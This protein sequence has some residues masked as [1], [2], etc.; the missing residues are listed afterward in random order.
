MSI[1]E[2]G[3]S[4]TIRQ[5]FRGK[6]VSHMALRNDRPDAEIIE[7]FRLLANHPKFSDELRDLIRKHEGT[8]RA[9]EALRRE[10]F[11]LEITPWSVDLKE[12]PFRQSVFKLIAAL[13]AAN[14]EEQWGITKDVFTRL[15][16]TAPEWPIGHDSYLSFRIRFGE[17]DAGVKRTFEA[18][19]GRFMYVH[20]KKSWW[21]LWPSHRRFFTGTK[22]VY[23]YLLA[24]NDSH[25]PTVEWIIVNLR[26]YRCRQSITDVRGPDSLADEGIVLGW[27]FPER[28]KAIDYKEYCAWFC[29]G[30]ELNIP[31]DHDEGFRYVPCV[32]F[33]HRLNSA[34]LSV[35]LSS[36]DKAWFSVPALQ[37]CN[38]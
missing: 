38:R 34:L 5:L 37:E 8:K 16:V 1:N 21:K 36:E 14:A 28:V 35:D 27:L 10:F 19:V 26:A 30:Y 29:A 2:E 3:F 25:K 17:G 31:C 22:I 20:R 18:H 23:P 24:G 9:I 11:P 7:T 6:E 13:R 15:V 33:D 32:Y 4:K 12:N